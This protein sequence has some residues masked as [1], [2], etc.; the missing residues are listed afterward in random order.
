[1]KAPA[2]AGPPR[3]KMLRQF[4]LIEKVRSYDPTADEALLNR[5]YVYA[6]RQHGSQKRASGDPYFAH[7]IEVAGILTD[8]R[9]DTE[10]IITALLH[11]VIEDTDATREKVAELFGGEIA[12]LVEGVTK[13]SKLE[14]SQE[15]LRQAENLRKFILAISKDVRVLLVKLA[16]RLHNMRTLHFIKQAAKRERIARETLDIYAPL[17]RSI[18]VHRICEE[19]EELAFA[20][21]NPV[22]RNA[23]L[24]RLETLRAEQGGAVFETGEHRASR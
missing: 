18:G 20:H 13:L 22:G 21:L 10:T 12:E 14:L 6:M 4:E 11:D 9:L 24:R 7:P 17:A 16:D 8:Y 2:V 15:H 23:I 5:A 19:L 3:P 1:M